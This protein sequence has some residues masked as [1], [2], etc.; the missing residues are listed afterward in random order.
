MYFANTSG[1]EPI[2][3]KPSAASGAFTSGAASALQT[4]ACNFTVMSAGSPFGP[5]SPY[6]EEKSKPFI[7][8]SAIVGILGA[9]ATRFRLVTAR[10]LILPDAASGS[11][12]A[13]GSAINWICPP[14]RSLSIG[15][16]PL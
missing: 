4:S 9:A 6:H 2:A 1:V 8:D 15:P 3:S 5:Q 10:A 12:E 16:A 11:D 7:P 13:I 14:M